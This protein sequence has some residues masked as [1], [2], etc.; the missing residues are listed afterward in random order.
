[1]KYKYGME[2]SAFNSLLPK[3]KIDVFFDQFLSSKGGFSRKFVQTS[4]HTANRSNICIYKKL[5]KFFG[6]VVIELVEAT[7]DLLPT[8]KG[9]GI[10]R[11]DDSVMF[12]LV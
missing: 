1:M 4:H 9:W 7:N 11:R 2:E 3:Q 8:L 6:K 5:L 12:C 10:L